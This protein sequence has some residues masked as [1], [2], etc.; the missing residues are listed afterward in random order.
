MRKELLIT[1]MILVGATLLTG[2]GNK[3]KYEEAVTMYNN[4]EYDS[5][6]SAFS[7]I[8]S[9]YEDVS[10]Y[11]SKLEEYSF[12]YSSAISDVENGNYDNAVSTLSELPKDYKQADTLIN[13]MDTIE[14]LVETEW[15]DQGN[16]KESNYGWEYFDTFSVLTYGD[17]IELRNHEEEYAD[18]EYLGDYSDSISISDLFDDGSA[19]VRCSERDNFTLDINGL[20]N[21]S[22]K[23]DTE[24][25]SSTFVKK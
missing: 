13:N 12:A 20:S 22:F 25:V 5:A 14:L 18:G 1:G 6:Y 23:K 7:D 24:Y 21:G 3:S 10:T 8:S 16:G 9:S 15:K 11:V 19:K 17:T 4:G 2:C